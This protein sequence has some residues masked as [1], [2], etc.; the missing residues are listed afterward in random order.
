MNAQ[1]VPM[2]DHERRVMQLMQ[3]FDQAT[4]LLPRMPDEHTRKL[5]AAL[6]LEEA[7]EFAQAAG[8]YVSVKTVDGA[9][10]LSTNR[11]NNIDVA[12]EGDFFLDAGAA[13]PSL[14]LMIDACSDISVVMTGTF[15]ACGV[16]VT[17]C[18]ELVDSNNL[19]KIAT[20]KLDPVSGKFIKAPNHP[21]PNYQHLLDS[22]GYSESPQDVCQAPT[23]C[24]HQ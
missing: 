9:V 7:L 14:P 23:C 20:G 6:I 4:P 5:R 17:P 10:T 19:L 2:T 11:A 18:L 3:S 1:I 16:P 22:L 8:L 21:V 24:A 13:E 12:K 15:V